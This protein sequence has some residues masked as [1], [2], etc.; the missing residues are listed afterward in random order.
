MQLHVCVTPC[1]TAGLRQLACFMEDLEASGLL[2]DSAAPAGA[3]AAAGALVPADS[4]SAAAPAGAGPDGG[5]APGE[6]G[7]GAAPA[8]GPAG[9]AGSEDPERVGRGAQDG[10]VPA[11]AGAGGPAAGGGGGAAEQRVLG[12]LEGSPGWHEARAH[13]SHRHKVFH[14]AECS[15]LRALIRSQVSQSPRTPA[16]ECTG[17]RTVCG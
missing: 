17:D 7:G 5:A 11:E 8:G 14:S 12:E 6:P 15:V 4:G 13:V 3:A 16:R 10:A 1:M 2:K 9:G